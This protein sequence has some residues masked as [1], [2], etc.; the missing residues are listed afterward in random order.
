M[1]STKSAPAADGAANANAF[2]PSIGSAP[3]VG[4]TAGSSVL[5]VA[6]PSSPASV[7]IAT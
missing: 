3:K 4:I 7:A 2:V 5:V 6:R 1:S